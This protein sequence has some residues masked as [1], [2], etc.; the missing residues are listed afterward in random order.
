ML[1]HFDINYNID[2]GKSTISIYEDGI[3]V[4]RFQVECGRSEGLA[5]LKLR[6]AAPALF[7]FDK[8]KDDQSTK[9]GWSTLFPRGPL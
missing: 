5:T 2:K 1:Y 6:L 8:E 7:V 4:H 9:V 3:L